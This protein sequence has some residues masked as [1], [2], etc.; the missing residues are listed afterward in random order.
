MNLKQNLTIVFLCS[1]S[2][3]F[4]QINTATIHLRGV[5]NT[6]YYIDGFIVY[7]SQLTQSDSINILKTVVSNLN[8][9][10]TNSKSVFSLKLSEQTFSGTKSIKGKK[11][12]STCVRLT[13]QNRQVKLIERDLNGKELT[14]I[15]IRVNENELAVENEQNMYHYK[16]TTKCR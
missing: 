16:R 2:L 13:L 12:E 14:P 5:S 9:C 8:G 1:L 3:S 7:H 4:G 11:S 6:N 15:N 10:W